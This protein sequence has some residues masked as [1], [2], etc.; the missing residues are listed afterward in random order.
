MFSSVSP[1][2][3]V[4][5]RLDGGQP[6]SKPLCNDAVARTKWAIRFGQ[7]GQEQSPAKDG[8]S[9]PREE[10]LHV[11][12]FNN[13]DTGSPFL[14]PQKNAHGT[15]LRKHPL[16]APASGGA[17]PA[18]IHKKT[19]PMAPSFYVH[20]LKTCLT[21]LRLSPHPDPHQWSP[22]GCPDTEQWPCQGL[23]NHCLSTCKRW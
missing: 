16:L 4:L 8:H 1:F 20:K 19:E 9:Q 10:V 23:S 18:R 11:G 22:C 2:L 7:G 13:L 5:N 6:M 21:E 12:G 15:T 17:S 3:V 14:S